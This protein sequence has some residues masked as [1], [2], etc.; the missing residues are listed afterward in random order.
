MGESKIQFKVGIVEFSGEGHSDWL[1]KQL[2]KI[3]EKVPNLLEIEVA[4]HRGAAN[5]GASGGLK[6]GAPKLSI[7]NVAGKLAA[8]S[9]S[10]LVIA[11]AAHM[12][13]V[14]KKSTFSRDDITKKMKEATGY[15]KGSFQ[16]NLT[17]TLARL[18]GNSSL[19]KSGGVYALHSNKVGE[20]NALLSK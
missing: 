5:D 9:G 13:F 20:L 1:A 12:H 17:T 11:A 16:A 2:D 3:L 7:I 19:T 8:K 10:D 14:E 4:P 6:H 15:Y 18:E